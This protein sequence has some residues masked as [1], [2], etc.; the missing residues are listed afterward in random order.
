VKVKEPNFTLRRTFRVEN[1][2]LL[3][4]SLRPAQVSGQ[5]CEGFGFKVLNCHAFDLQPNAARDLVIL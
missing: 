4:I 5:L 3:P 1:T 2:G